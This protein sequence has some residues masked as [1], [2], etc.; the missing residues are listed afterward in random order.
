VVRATRYAMS[1]Q[2][3]PGEGWG[4]FAQLYPDVYHVL[5][6][7]TDLVTWAGD[8]LSDSKQ[9]NMVVRVLLVQYGLWSAIPCI[10][11]SA[12]HIPFLVILFISS[13]LMV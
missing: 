10:A 8:M 7:Q 3:S 5:Y 1:R 9:H 11:V 4:K 13:W 6:T 12:C 2:L